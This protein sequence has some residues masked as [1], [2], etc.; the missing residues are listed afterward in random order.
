MSR[1]IFLEGGIIGYNPEYV[2]WLEDKIDALETI[3]AKYDDTVEAIISLDE[4]SDE[5]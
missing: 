1:K 3:I 4:L 2:E 5:G